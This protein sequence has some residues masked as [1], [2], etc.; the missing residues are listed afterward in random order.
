MEKRFSIILALLVG[1]SA[2]KIWG[3]SKAQNAA[4]RQAPLTKDY[5]RLVHR[6]QALEAPEQSRPLPPI[7]EEMQK[8]IQAA[9]KRITELRRNQQARRND[10][11]SLHASV[12]GMNL[13]RDGQPKEVS[14][15]PTSKPK[16]RVVATDPVEA[17][18]FILPSELPKETKTTKSALRRPEKQKGL[19]VSFNDILQVQEYRIPSDIHNNSS[20]APT[21]ILNPTGELNPGVANFLRSHNVRYSGT[22]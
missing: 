12:I 17:D 7:D 15:S 16:E 3:P 20:T 4:Q 8:K 9:S 14:A 2:G 13:A 6:P 10:A 11:L 22:R 18:D 1:L 21:H 19:K 5:A